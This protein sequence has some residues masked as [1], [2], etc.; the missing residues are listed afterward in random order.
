MVFYFVRKGLGCIINRLEPQLLSQITQCSILELHWP[1]G[2]PSVCAISHKTHLIT[3]P[4]WL[5]ILLALYEVHLH[6]FLLCKKRFG[7]RNKSIG[8][9]TVVTNYT[10]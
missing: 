5:W 6:G 8:A 4:G 10:V 3:V 1:S 7:M 2:W 9:L